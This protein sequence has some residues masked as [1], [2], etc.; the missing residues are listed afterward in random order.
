MPESRRHAL[1]RRLRSAH[2]TLWGNAHLIPA[3]RRP[4][5]RVSC[6]GRWRFRHIR[7]YEGTA[8]SNGGREEQDVGEHREVREPT[9][10]GRLYKSR[11]GVFR[12]SF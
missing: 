1:S 4:A 2:G 11:F 8:K 12:L 7:L 10:R 5:A 9:P 3:Q 6:T